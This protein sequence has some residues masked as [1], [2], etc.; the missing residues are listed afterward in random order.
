MTVRENRAAVRLSGWGNY[1]V[2]PCHVSRPETVAALRDVVLRGSEQS[3]IARGLG[4]SY[5]DSALNRDQ[6]VILQTGQ[7]RL[8]AFDAEQ[9]LLTCEA[10]ASLGEIIDVFLPRGWAL[11]TT[12]GTKYV[13]VGGAIAADVHGKNHHCDGSLGNF[14]VALDLLSAAGDVLHCSREENPDVFWATIGGMGLTGCILTATLRL[15]PVETAYVAVEYRR[16]AN[17]VDTLARLSATNHDFRFSVAWIDCLARGNS[18]GRSVLMLA[19]HAPRSALPPALQNDPLR[20]PRRGKWPVPFNFPSWALNAWSVGLFNEIYYRRHPDGGRLVDFDTFFYP[21]D[22]VSHWNR[23]YGR[24]GFVQYQVLF[25]PQTSHQALAR[26]LQRVA[27]RRQTPFLAVLKSMGPAG[28]GWLSFPREGHTLALDLPHRG[29]STNRLL[30]E[31]DELVLEHGGRLYLAKDA[32]MSAETFQA[33][34]PAVAR[35]RQLKA[36]LDPD[37]RFS[38]SQ[39][40]RLG[41]V[42]SA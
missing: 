15:A 18:L 13:T 4:R 42:G 3:Y 21:L 37:N 16:T 30:R 27:A 39:A 32:T 41:I 11:P 31:L 20:L 36:Q 19:N 17:L 38:S 22:A 29:E 40:R 14:V 33:M 34:Y 9:G 25:P 7:D 24:R 5:G 23:I 12:P 2:E 35:F 26:L 28:A 10:G 6:G 8:L 1:P